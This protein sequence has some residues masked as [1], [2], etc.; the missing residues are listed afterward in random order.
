MSANLN[1]HLKI[2]VVL[3]KITSQLAY[4]IGNG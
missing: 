1:N 2:K 4:K 3:S